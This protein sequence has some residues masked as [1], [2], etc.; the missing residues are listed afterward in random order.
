MNHSH[1][2]T[3]DP[4]DVVAPE[5]VQIKAEPDPEPA[6]RS[7]QLIDSSLECSI[8][9]APTAHGQ[10][11]RVQQLCVA[12]SRLYNLRQH[13]PIDHHVY[14]WEC[15]NREQHRCGSRISTCL[16][17]GAHF[18]MDMSFLDH[19][20]RCD[21]LQQSSNSVVA[22]NEPMEC[23]FDQPCKL[24]TTADGGREIFN[25]GDFSYHLE[26]MRNMRY[27]WLCS[28]THDPPCGG[29]ISSVIV[30]GRHV[31]LS[32]SF[33]AH[34]A[35]HQ[36]IIVDAQSPDTKSVV[37]CFKA[38]TE[39]ASLST[40]DCPTALL[41]IEHSAPDS[42]LTDDDNEHFGEGYD[43]DD[44]EYGK[45]ECKN[46]QDD[47]EDD[48][49]DDSDDDED[50]KPIAK[51]FPKP[52]QLIT[53][54]PQRMHRPDEVVPSFTIPTTRG[55]D[56]LCVEG[57]VYYQERKPNGERSYWACARR[58]NTQCTGR[59]VTVLDG[60]QHVVQSVTMRTHNHE[61]TNTNAD[62][63]TAL[64]QLRKLAIELKCDAA[65]IVNTV[66]SNCTTKTKKELPDEKSLIRKVKQI[67][68][69]VG[70]LD[71]GNHDPTNT[72][73]S[74][75]TALAQLRKLAIESKRDAASIVTSVVPNCTTKTIKEL[76]NKKKV[77]Q[78]RLE[79]GGH[80]EVDDDDEDDDDED[81]DDD[82]DNE[83]PSVSSLPVRELQIRRYM[84]LDPNEPIECSTVPSR[85]GNEKLCVLGYVYHL[86]RKATN[87]SFHWACERRK[88]YDPPC[89]ARVV[90]HLD[91]TLHHV[92]DRRRGVRTHNHNSPPDDAA[93]A[94][95][96]SRRPYN[97]DEM[98]EA[99]AKRLS[100]QLETNSIIPCTTI[101]TAR[102]N[103]TLFVQGYTYHCD[104]RSEMFVYWKCVLSKVP[105]NR[106]PGRVTTTLQGDQCVVLSATLRPHTHAADVTDVDQ[107]RYRA[108]AQLR[109][110]AQETQMDAASII[111]TVLVDCS[112]ECRQKLGSMSVLK[113][114]VVRARKG[115]DNASK[116]WREQML[117][118]LE[119]ERF[120]AIGQLKDMARKTTMDAKTI[121][122]AVLADCSTECRTKLGNVIELRKKV[123]RTRVAQAKREAK[124][125]RKA[126]KA[127]QLLN[128]RESKPEEEADS[129]VTGDISGVSEELDHLSTHL[130]KVE[131][132]PSIPFAMEDF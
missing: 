30:A 62:K 16:E 85:R 106:C 46:E 129:N 132:N 76:P 131:D 52:Q 97:A 6:D 22:K 41:K 18:A 125:L 82:D 28:Q 127:A 3:I 31:V 87:N 118:P 100:R 107:E 91:D 34:S 92:I 51:L 94:R 10:N 77:K 64:A 66:I 61:P 9:I 55:N 124:I 79:V 109:Q 119:R 123:G 98:R 58:K 93:S 2:T 8:V 37:D 116:V 44:E 26:S 74:K 27:Q 95:R 33:V 67:R 130:V 88:R 96:P 110:L 126:A 72:K 69:E 54:W 71:V 83:K 45:Q 105:V 73:T 12:K 21:R 23:D 112:E 104:R 32:N 111:A 25:V 81:E 53:F 113:K 35:C 48:S 68:A 60:D 86:E 43:D 1:E 15:S 84:D 90:T 121:V 102:G 56:K 78:I 36:A 39:G 65:R 40:D 120:A 24:Q 117:S 128:Q 11:S 29:S 70:G 75:E 20:S 4:M 80:D 7:L 19:S 5:F 14:H 115:Q 114:K 13:S 103:E 63:E 59:L 17:G 122:A 99:E 108:C 47:D 57:Y 50:N 49:D 38:D 42:P 89:L 101:P